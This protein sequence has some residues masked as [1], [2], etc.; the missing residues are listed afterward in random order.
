MFYSTQQGE[1][2]D[3][4][5]IHLKLKEYM[6]IHYSE[7]DHGWTMNDN[8]STTKNCIWNQLR[9]MIIEQFKI[10]EIVGEHFQHYNSP[11]RWTPQAYVWTLQLLENGNYIWI[12]L[13]IILRKDKLNFRMTTEKQL[14]VYLRGKHENVTAVI[15]KSTLKMDTDPLQWRYVTS[16]PYQNIAIKVFFSQIS[17][18]WIW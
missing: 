15:S 1:E 14:I 4:Q 16:M 17:M 3:K 10:L 12:K 2:D 18:H 6:S 8:K 13:S 11:F 9:D 7:E 5:Y